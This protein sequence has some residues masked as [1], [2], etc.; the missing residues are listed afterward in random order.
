M[1][2]FGKGILK[3]FAGLVV[4]PVSGILDLFSKTTEGIKNTV[5]TEDFDLVKIR[6]PR[7]FYGKYKIIKTYNYYHS[8]VIELLNKIDNQYQIKFYF[9]QPTAQI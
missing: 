5:N 4:K 9:T 6:K 8:D 3:G 2:G 1:T 7:I